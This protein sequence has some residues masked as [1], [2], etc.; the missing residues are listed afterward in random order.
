[1]RLEPVYKGIHYYFTLTGL[2]AVQMNDSIATT[3][4][5]VKDGQV[6]AGNIPVSATLQYSPDTYGNGKAGTLLDLYKALFAYSDSAKAYF[7][8]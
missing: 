2:I 1:M 6:Y 8:N 5:G 7:A 4:Y 3:L